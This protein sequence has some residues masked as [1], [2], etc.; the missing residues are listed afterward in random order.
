M[1][2]GHPIRY[3]TREELDT[4]KWDDCLDKSPN[5]LIYGRS[6]YL[7]PMTG[8]QWDALILGDYQAVMPLTWKKK[9]GVRYLYQ[10]PFTQQLG[11]FSPHPIPPSLVETFLAGLRRHFRFAEIFLNYGNPHATLKACTNFILPLD[12]AYQH[13]A[14]NYK[15]DLVHNL[16]V[17]ARSPLRYV[18]DFDLQTSLS[19]YQQLYQER[20]P[21]VKAQDY[22]NF[23]KL[24]VFLQDKGRDEVRDEERDKGRLLVRAATDEGGQ[25][26]ALAVLPTIAGRMH[27]LQSTTLPLGR[28]AEA[29]HFLLDSLVREMA[30]SRRI[31]D[32][33]GSD[34]PGIAH[35]YA[36]FGARD[37]P[38]FFYRYNGLPWPFRLLRRQD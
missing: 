32:F 6:F 17:A 19:L 5:G 18:K 36:N 21:H 31:L 1:N 2:A 28:Q 3:I 15:K 27:L 38:Y 8:G 22:R 24:C 7:D 26:L 37:Q 29:N 23:E 9:W 30:D 25:P 34:L 12:K 13:I 35:F 4:E 11:I 10:P 20:T 33:E 14:G 16:S